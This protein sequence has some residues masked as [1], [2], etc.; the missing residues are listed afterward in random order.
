ML[1]TVK[2]INQRLFDKI[3]SQPIVVLLI[4]VFAMIILATLRQLG[5]Y[6]AGFVFAIVVAVVG[7]ASINIYLFRKNKKSLPVFLFD[8]LWV[9]IYTLLV[10]ATIYTFPA[11]DTN[12]FLVNETPKNLTFAEAFYFSGVTFTTLGYGDILPH[13]QFRWYALMEVLLGMVLFGLF[14]TTIARLPMRGR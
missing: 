9:M 12:F 5:F 10:F 13:G 6:A 2:T 11:N 4:L 8:I 3:L 14:I 1:R 7:V